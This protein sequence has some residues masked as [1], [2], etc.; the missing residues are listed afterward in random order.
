MIKLQGIIPANHTVPILV[1]GAG[2]TGSHLIENLAVLNDNMIKL[3]FPGIK[4]TVL[5]DDVVSKTNVGRQRFTFDDVG[6]NKALTLIDRINY[7]YGFDWEAY[8]NR[9]AY[10]SSVQTPHYGFLISCVDSI[11][12]RQIIMTLYKD[13]PAKIK[14]Y[15]YWMDIGNGRDYGQIIMGSYE[16]KLPTFFDVFPSIESSNKLTD[17]EPTGC[18]TMDAMLK[19]SLFINSIMALYAT[20][21]L[22]EFLFNSFL[23]YSMMFININTFEINVK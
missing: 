16:Y 10:H 9:L 13:V 5:D 2:G 4:V 20:N 6:Q 21:M 17:E 12:S 22:K 18:S 1:I 14:G 15:N 19:Q 7:Q 11:T 8:P 3:D 23:N